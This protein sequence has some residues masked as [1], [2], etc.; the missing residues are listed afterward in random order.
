MILKLLKLLGAGLRNGLVA[1]GALAFIGTIGAIADYALT[2]GSGTNFASKV[3][4]TVHYAAGVI[5]DATV[6]ETQCAAVDTHGQQLIDVNTSNN[7][8]YTAITSPIAS[9]S[10]I[11]GKVGI[12][13]TTPGTTNAVQAIAGTSGGTSSA[14]GVMANSTNSTNVKASAGQIY[15]VQTGN[16][17]ATVPAYLK[18]Y[19]KATA[20]TCGT[21]TPVKRIVIPANSLG[22]GNNVS[23]PI[24][25]QFTSGI[26]Y[27]VTAGIAD[28]DTTA[29]AA[30]TVIVN[31]GYK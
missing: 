12:D 30:S 29:V 6:G 3:I 24:G 31:I 22:G 5:C 28:N 13:Q 9:G 20:P 11:I 1:I 15:S 27:C 23:I 10:N 25:W 26:G 2:Q 16:I 17:S 21:D 19:D 14:G 7:N 18:L 8:L 4:S